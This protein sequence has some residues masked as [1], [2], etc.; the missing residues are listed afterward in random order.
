M[1]LSQIQ[2]AVDFYMILLL[3]VK[4]LRKWKNECYSSLLHL[5]PSPRHPFFKP[6]EEKQGH[7]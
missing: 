3:M 4:S 6:R 1:V 2:K 7:K 5:T